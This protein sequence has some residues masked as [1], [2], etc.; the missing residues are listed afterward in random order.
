MQVAMSLAGTIRTRAWAS[1]GMKVSVGVAH[2]KLLAKLASAA[3]KPD[4]VHAVVGH[5]SVEDLMRRAPVSRLP[6]AAHMHMRKPPL[7]R[8]TICQEASSW[9]SF[10]CR[11]FSVSCFAFLPANG[12]GLPTFFIPMH[13][14]RARVPTYNDSNVLQGLG[15]R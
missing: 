14:T 9:D 3:A 7:S 11:C 2:N 6:G 12:T 5:S 8:H 4:G 15:V 10:F 1:L 13:A